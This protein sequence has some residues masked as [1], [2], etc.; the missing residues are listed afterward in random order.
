MKKLTS[1][2]VIKLLLSGLFLFDFSSVNAAQTL[3][4]PLGDLSASQ[5]K[6]TVLGQCVYGGYCN[7]TS[8]KTAYNG[9][10]YIADVGSPVYA[11]C[12]GTVKKAQPADR[13]IVIEHFNC[14]SFDSL[15]SYYGNVNLEKMALGLFPVIDNK[16]AFDEEYEFLQPVYTITANNV[17]IDYTVGLLPVI[18]QH[19]QTRLEKFAAQK[20][21]DISEIA[22]LLHSTNPQWVA[23]AQYFSQLYDASWQAFYNNQ[24]LPDL[25]W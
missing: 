14:G 10:N 9:V 20:D 18:A 6:G 21:I 17:T 2:F 7:G 16:I 15:F 3:S 4:Q 1:H 24:P 5:M 11:V 8:T 12:D 23:E 22:I 25:V 13:F 19:I